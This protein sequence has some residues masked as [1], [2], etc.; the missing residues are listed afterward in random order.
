MRSPYL[1]QNIM[2]FKIQSNP[3][4]AAGFVIALVL[5][6]AL[7]IYLNVS[8]KVKN[9]AVFRGEG[10]NITKRKRIHVDSEFYNEVKHI[11]L[12]KKEAEILE[13]ILKEEGDENP[14]A[15]LYN[16]EKTNECF[17]YA[18]KKIVQE[19]G[20]DGGLFRIL[21]LFSIRN[22]VEYFYANEKA[23][24]GTVVRNFRRKPMN[25]PCVFYQVISIKQGFSKK[26]KLVVENDCKYAGTILNV[27][28]GGCAIS[29]TQ[30]IKASKMIKIEFRAFKKE[31]A[32]LGQIL[33][34]NKDGANWVYHIKFLRLP[35]TSLAVLNAYI[36][37]Y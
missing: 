14:I 26:R 15:V 32:A 21:D 13:K 25:V 12:N 9:S 1:L 20:E 8:K 24:S 11:G 7:I 29:V 2:E 31:V 35:K 34:F 23:D 37:E 33:R 3:M 5:L 27:S 22:A 28:Q 4:D 19:E 30:H 36:F 16:E 17:K 10:I 18:Y 6:T